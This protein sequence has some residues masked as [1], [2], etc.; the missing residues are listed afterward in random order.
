VARYG[1]RLRQAQGQARQHR[2]PRQTLPVV[3]EPSSRPL[4]TRRAT[5]L[6]LRRPERQDN[7]EAAQL[8]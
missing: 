6:V 7:N 1:Q 2:A 5:W 4:T 3:T 8:A